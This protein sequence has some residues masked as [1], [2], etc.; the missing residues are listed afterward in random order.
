MLNDMPEDKLLSISPYPLTLLPPVVSRWAIEASKY[1]WW[2]RTR[3]HI[4]DGQERRSHL[5]ALITAAGVEIKAIEA[6]EKEMEVERE[7]MKNVMDVYAEVQ[8]RL[9]EKEQAEKEMTKE[10]A[11][12]KTQ[13]IVP[14]TLSHL[15][16]S[17]ARVSMESVPASGSTP[18]A[19]PA[20]SA[21]PSFSSQIQRPPVDFSSDDDI[22]ESPPGGNGDE[23]EDGDEEQMDL[24]KADG[25]G[26]E[27]Q[28]GQEAR[29]GDDDV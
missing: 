29:D 21:A 6:R 18:P 27:K 9:R 26:I 12:M 11:E 19:E 8:Q 4:V 16:Q 13:G 23:D 24:D 10:I 3:M 2:G 7:K 1:T 15:K 25:K 22:P 20:V 17:K 28:S 14:G 5:E